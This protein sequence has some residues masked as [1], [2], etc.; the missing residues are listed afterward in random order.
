MAPSALGS[1][2]LLA[3][4]GLALLLANARYW[5]SV[6]WIVRGELKRWKLYAQA[7]EDPELRTLALA[8]LH[9]EAFHAEAAAMLATGAPRAHRASVIEAIVALELL[10]DYLD[11]LTERSSVDPLD[12]GKRLFAIFTDAAAGCVGTG[13]SPPPP[14]TSDGY[15]E[16]LSRAASAAIARLPAAAAITQVS[17]KVAARAGQAQTRMHAVPALGTAQ[18]EGWARAE[19]QGTGLEWRELVA[20]AASSV[21]ALHALTAAAADPDMSPQQAAEIVPS[22]LSMCVVLT[23]LDGLVDYGEDRLSGGPDWAGYLGLFPAVEELPD[24]L[25]K[26]ATRAAVQAAAL[27]NGA[28]HV[29]ILVGVV[30]YYG[31]APGAEGEL[32]RPVLAR[33]RADLAPLIYPTLAITRAWR[34]LGQ[35]NTSIR[36]QARGEAA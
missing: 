14:R 9:G 11:G 17:Q 6:A 31:S 24:L 20:G 1:R 30:G 25:G 35:R 27:P 34:A 8:K 19:A 26:A 12:Q 33:L 22:Y 21:L 36:S 13:G 7:I 32:A 29:M 2:R 28:H 5:T 4:A 23:L 10:F 18:L 3:R 16:A 15:L